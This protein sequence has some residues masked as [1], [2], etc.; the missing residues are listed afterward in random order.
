M[1]PST[2]LG[3]T[4]AAAAL[5][6][7]GFSITPAT[8]AGLASRGGGPPYDLFNGRARYQYGSLI[9]WAESRVKVPQHRARMVKNEAQHAA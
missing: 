3:R 9:D 2:K 1:H 4:S 6:E 5:N 7:A 8:L